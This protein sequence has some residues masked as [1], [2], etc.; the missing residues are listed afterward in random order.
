MRRVLARIRL[1]LGWRQPNPD[2]LTPVE[3]EAVSLIAYEGRDAL[4]RA[5]EQADYCAARG[6]AKGCRFWSEVAAEV[7]KRTGAK[8]APRA[9]HSR[10]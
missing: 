4:R 6:S 2:G 7:A 9:K 10:S 5:R 1:W 8:G 3:Y